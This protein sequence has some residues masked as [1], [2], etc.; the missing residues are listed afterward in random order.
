MMEIKWVFLIWRCMFDDR[1]VRLRVEKSIF[2]YGYIVID[3]FNL[4]EMGYGDWMCF[5]VIDK[6]RE[7]LDVGCFMEL[8]WDQVIDLYV[9]FVNV[10]FVEDQEGQ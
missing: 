3:G 1:E 4:V 9:K 6:M 8:I 5:L 10:L 2:G 7:E